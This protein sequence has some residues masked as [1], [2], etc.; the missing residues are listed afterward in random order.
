M[1]RFHCM[2]IPGEV[3]CWWIS[4]TVENLELQADVERVG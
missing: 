4:G 3:E 2:Y 1:E